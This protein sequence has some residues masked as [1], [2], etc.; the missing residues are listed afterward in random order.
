LQFATL[1]PDNQIIKSVELKGDCSKLESF[2][3]DC[4]WLYYTKM[5]DSFSLCAPSARI[6][7]LGDF[8]LELLSYPSVKWIACDSGTHLKSEVFYNFPESLADRFYRRRT[9]ADIKILDDKVP[10]YLVSEN[11][12]LIFS[13]TLHPPLNSITLVTNKLHTAYYIPWIKKQQKKD[14]K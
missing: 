13:N 6:F 4:K 5:L 2:T 8:N 11:D 14:M 12:E 9:R 3:I 1:K 7:I 10:V